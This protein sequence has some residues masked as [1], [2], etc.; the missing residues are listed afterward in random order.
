MSRFT[1]ALNEQI[2]REFGASQQYVAIAVSLRLL[3]PC[4]SSR[5]TSTGKR[6]KSETTR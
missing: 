6:S 1:D 3:R 4:P 2:G 5:R